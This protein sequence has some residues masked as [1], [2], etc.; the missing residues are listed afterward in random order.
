MYRLA[1]I[2]VG[3]PVSVDDDKIA[4]QYHIGDS[5]DGGNRIARDQVGFNPQFCQS[6]VSRL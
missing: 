5:R 6:A 4:G 2:I 1:N 3:T